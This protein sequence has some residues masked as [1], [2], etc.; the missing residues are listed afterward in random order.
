MD[1]P[2]V[3]PRRHFLSLAGA[4]ALGLPGASLAQAGGWPSRPIKVVCN[5][6]PGSSPDVLIRAVSQPLHQALGQ[7]VVIENR[8]GASGMIGAELVAK[9]PPDGHTLL[10]TAGSTMTTNPHVFAKM[11]FDPERDL[12]PVAGLA[13]L[14]LFLVTR[15]DFP[16]RNVREFLAWLK[17]HP[18]KAT[19]GSAGNATGLHIAGEM[20]K[21]QAGVYAVH[22]PYRG[23]SPALQDLLAGQIDFYFDPGIALQHVKAGKLKM[24]AIAAPQRSPLYADVPTLDEAGL[25]GF[26]A[27]T[28]H[29]VYAPAGTPE[30]IL[31]RLNQAINAAL[32]MPAVRAQVAAM[33][34]E[35]TP[36]T[37]AQY[38]ALMADDSRRYAQVIRDRRITGG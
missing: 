23:A 15:G 2:P 32:V 22:V 10:M 17:R 30:P 21:G 1:R 34:A 5:F 3:L 14:N 35:P 31:E 27:G 28:T 16:A 25:K 19:Y 12:V 37:R 26:D 13:R 11:A 8:A 18:G 29:G 7:P 38:A 4:A 6:P 9:A 36:M 24:M 20:L 33:G